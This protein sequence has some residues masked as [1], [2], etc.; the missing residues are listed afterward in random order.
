MDHTLFSRPKAIFHSLW[1]ACS[2]LIMM[3]GFW[4]LRIRVRLLSSDVFQGRKE[5]FPTFLGATWLRVKTAAAWDSQLEAVVVKELFCLYAAHLSDLGSWL[6]C[7]SGCIVVMIWFNYKDGD[8]KGVCFKQLTVYQFN[9]VTT[10]F[11][12]IWFHNILSCLTTQYVGLDTKF[13]D[14]SGSL[15]TCLSLGFASTP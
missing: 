5:E 2:S 4:V 10:K 14:V 11:Q 8:C 12:L 9:A 6:F 13:I 15:R 3:R 1:C 7:E